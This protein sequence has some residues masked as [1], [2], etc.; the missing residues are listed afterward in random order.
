[1]TDSYIL[2]FHFSMVNCVE[3]DPEEMI[4]FVKEFAHI[5]THVPVP[6]PGNVAVVSLIHA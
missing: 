3:R 4:V 1:M 5:C 6:P 2:F